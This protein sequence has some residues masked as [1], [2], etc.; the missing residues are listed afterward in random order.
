[1]IGYVEDRTF[2]KNSE[3]LVRI[4]RAFSYIISKL[5]LLFVIEWNGVGLREKNHARMKSTPKGLEQTARGP[6]TVVT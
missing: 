3:D 4:P 5:S 1:M 6:G 2:A